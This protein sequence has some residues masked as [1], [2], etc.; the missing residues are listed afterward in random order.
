MRTRLGSLVLA[1]SIGSSLFA[2]AEADAQECIPPRILLVMDMSSSMT[3]L[4]DGTSTVKWE[5]AQSAIHTVLTTHGDA[6]H[7][8][9]LTF[10]A[11]PRAVPPATCGWTWGWIRPR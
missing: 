1:A 2:A 10:P 8:G 5:A 4:I 11:R 6:A 3:D 7:Y 9:L